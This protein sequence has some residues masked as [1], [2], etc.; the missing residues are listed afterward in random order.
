MKTSIIPLGSSMRR[1][2]LRSALLLILFLLGCLGLPLTA[3]A[4]SPPPD[5]NFGG[6]NTAEGSGALFSLTPG[7]N[8]TALGGGA[9][10]SLTTGKQNT[11]TPAQAL[12]YNPPP[13]KTSI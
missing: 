1:S 10:F 3:Q 6:A 8:N 11:P 7:S 5:G 13:A 4:V 12:R 2:P 9:L